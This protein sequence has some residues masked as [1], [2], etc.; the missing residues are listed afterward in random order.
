[1]KYD[2]TN[3]LAV[4]LP[5]NFTSTAD[6]PTEVMAGRF[7]AWRSIIKDLINYFRE[8][9]SIQEE[10]VRQQSRLQQAVGNSS[11]STN[12]NS[13]EADSIKRFFL[14]HGNGSVLDIPNILFKYHQKNVTNAS[15]TLKDI[16]SII[17]PKLEELRKDLLVKI[18]EIKNL[19]NDFKNNLTKELSETKLLISQYNQ[20]IDFSNKLETGYNNSAHYVL[21]ESENGK[22]DPYLVKIKLDKQLKRQI[23]E[24]NYLYDAY[25]NLQ[26]AGRQLESIVVLEIQNYVSMFLNLV[27]E[28]NSTFSTYLLPNMNNG[29]LGKE[30]NFEWDAFIERNLPNSNLSVSA[31]GNQSTG[32]RNGTFIDLG[33]PK[34]HLSDFVIKNFDT[35]LNIAVRE[36]Y[37]ERRSKFLK[38]YTSAWYVLTCNYI[39]EFKSNDRKRDPNPVMSLSLDSCTVSDHSKNDGKSDGIY[40]FI[41]TSR[42]NNALMH[43][44]HKW[45][46]RTD[47]FKNMIE[48]FDSIKQMTSLPTPAARARAITGKPKPVSAESIS[49]GHAISRISTG[50][51]VQSPSRSLKTMS[52][53][54]TT[55]SQNAYK[56][57]SLTQ[58]NS[59]PNHKRLSS[60]FSQRNNQSPRLGN[61][62]N[63]DGTIITPVETDDM[64]RRSASMYSSY[65][66]VHYQNE[67]Q[68][69]QRVQTP[70]DQQQQQQQ[71]P[72]QQQQPYPQQYQRLEQQQD[73]QSPSIQQPTAFRIIPVDPLGNGSQPQQ[74]VGGNP[75]SGYQYYIPSNAQQGTQQFYDPVQQQYFTLTPSVPVSQSTTLTQQTSTPQPQYFSTSPQPQAIPGSPIQPFGPAFVPQFTQQQDQ[76][77]LHPNVLPYPTVSRTD[78]YHN[79]DTITEDNVDQ[80][81]EQQ[82]QLNDEGTH[83]APVPN[84]TNHSGQILSHYSGDE[85]STLMSGGA[86]GNELHPM[87]SRKSNDVHHAGDINIEVTQD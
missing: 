41:L 65:N 82:Q 43:K 49:S 86:Q 78:L 4:Q 66:P 87:E 47:T 58:V 46:F 70:Q 32:V 77:N 35:N 52:T 56:H 21:H 61:L 3:P 42:L 79:D 81:D 19:Q 74:Q 38:N 16:N 71:E 51:T 75:P 63:S 39:H 62:I 18:K 73:P 5:Y 28:E 7:A 14:G 37:L 36:G 44:N 31:V 45:V 53:N 24:E 26:N 29:F 20:A 76:S 22:L 25:A 15:K 17:I 8:Y 23:A 40:K 11:S 1:M 12:S 10:I 48:W 72:Q 50:N 2:T 33:I 13:E 69:Q 54:N 68:Q 30:S 27:N 59:N 57:R 83:L 60:T 9:S 34:R 6:F 84:N 67:Q 55:A 80:H 85:V 64:V